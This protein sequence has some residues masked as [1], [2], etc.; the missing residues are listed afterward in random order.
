MSKAKAKAKRRGASAPTAVRERGLAL[1]AWLIFLILGNVF[2]TYGRIQS[3]LVLT[4]V[5]SQSLVVPSWVFLL[6]AIL[7]VSNIFA[8][9][10]VWR[11]QKVGIYIIAVTLVL[12]ILIALIAFRSVPSAIVALVSVGI[13]YWLI[14]PKWS[15]FS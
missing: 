5:A 14:R 7:S 3:Y 4:E 6:Q 10:L 8:L 9:A 12:I 11:W 13:L 2:V 15:L 1:T